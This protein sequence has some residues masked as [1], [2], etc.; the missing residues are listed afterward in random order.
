MSAVYELTHPG[1]CGG[2]LLCEFI[3][4]GIRFFAGEQS[5]ELSNN[6]EVVQDMAEEKE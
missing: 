2:R 6:A 3:R 4:S 5:F 1:R